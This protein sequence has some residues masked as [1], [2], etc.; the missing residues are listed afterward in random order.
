MERHKSFLQRALAGTVLKSKMVRT[1]TDM[2]ALVYSFSRESAALDIDTEMGDD[3]PVRPCKH[4]H[5]LPYSFLKSCTSLAWNR[6]NSIISART[7]LDNMARVMMITLQGS[8]FNRTVSLKNQTICRLGVTIT[9]SLS[10]KA[11]GT[12]S[13]QEKI[14]SGLSGSRCMLRN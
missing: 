6:C 5:G 1:L 10:G 11:F 14:H 3:I 13:T 8:I 4:F 7:M 9:G 2:K 12:F